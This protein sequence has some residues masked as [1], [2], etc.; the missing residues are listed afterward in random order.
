MY[1]LYTIATHITYGTLWLIALVHPKIRRFVRGRK[2]TFRQVREQLD[3]KRPIIWM[4]TASLGEYEQGLPVLKE[5]RRSYPG[6]QIL[7]S[8]FSP[9]GYEVMKHKAEADIV[10]YLPIDS[11]RNARK[12]LQLCR[13]S[14]AI[15]IKYEI[16]PNYLRQLERENI[17]SLLVSAIFRE[18]HIFFK[19][20]GGFMRKALEKF[21]HICVQDADS[22]EL[23]LEK[24]IKQT[25]VSGDTRFDRVASI[26]SGS[27][28][29]T[30]VARFKG[31]QL[32]FVAGSSWPEDDELLAH[33]INHGPKT[34]KYIIA[35]H[36]IK[37][38]DL[39]RLAGSIQEKVCFW[40]DTREGADIPASARVLILDTIGLLNRVYHSADLAYVGGGFAT[41]LHNTLEPAVFGIPVLIGPDFKQFREA[42]E[43]VARQGILVVHD[44]H[45]LLE[46]TSRLVEDT[47]LR[48]RTGA[49]NAKYVRE[50]TGATAAVCAK[51]KDLLGTD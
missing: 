24:G 21:S 47:G 45:A 29:V 33:C 1:L 22:K 31:D 37:Q 35:P 42:R 49:I 11:N 12:F 48:S 9:S 38:K 23:L 15:F 20:Y 39:E 16:W 25:S 2:H 8:F 26:A 50:N 28:P 32:C 14:L 40:S 51:I 17:P 43:L 46:Y 5:I 3:P 19:R 6:H 7:L 30:P 41:G 10:I 34:L 13:P 44:K 36:K 4:H 27:E 18:E